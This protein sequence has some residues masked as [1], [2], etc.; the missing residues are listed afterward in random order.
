[1]TVLP[2]A[3]AVGYE[4]NLTILLTRYVSLTPLAGDGGAPGT[5]VD[6]RGSTLENDVR[7]TGTSCTSVEKSLN[8]FL[9][10][11]CRSFFRTAEAGGLGKT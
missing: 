7:E 6:R 9:S 10:Y 1:M 5:V 4:E 11:W 3:E 2:T 8:G